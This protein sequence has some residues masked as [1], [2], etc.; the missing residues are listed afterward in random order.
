MS[1]SRHTNYL[2]MH[3]SDAERVGIPHGELADVISEA[4]M[5]RVPVHHLEDLQPGTVALPHGWG[6]Q[7]ARGLSVA[8]KTSGVNVNILASDGPESLEPLSGM[9]RLTAIEVE[10]RP[11]AGP[12][13]T[14][15][16]SGLPAQ[17]EPAL[18]LR[19][20]L[21]SEDPSSEDQ[22]EEDPSSEVESFSLQ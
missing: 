2:Y 9:A 19:E 12:W 7:H 15:S 20:L 11:A 8:K 16:W 18:P 4:G 14:E 21:F 10:V 1:G 22:V 17:E 13:N 3:P 6:H 5:V